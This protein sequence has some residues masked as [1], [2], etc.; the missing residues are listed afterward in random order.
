[1]ANHRAHRTRRTPDAVVSLTRVCGGIEVD[2]HSQVAM[3]IDDKRL[4]I[5]LSALAVLVEQ[6]AEAEAVLAEPGHV[7]PAAPVG[8]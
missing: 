5:E 7:P 4:V 6:R 3:L 1:M 2:D 8:R